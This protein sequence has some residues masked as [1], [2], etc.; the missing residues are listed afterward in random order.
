MKLFRYLFV[1]AA[2]SI[3]PVYAQQLPTWGSQPL[4]A[5]HCSGNLVGNGTN[6]VTCSSTSS[7]FDTLLGSTVGQVAYRN[8]GGWVGTALVP[9]ASGGTGTASPGLTAGTN[10][11]ITGSWPNQ[12]IAASG[13]SSTTTL[14]IGSTPISGGVANAYLYQCSSGNLLCENAA[15]GTGSPVN[16]TS[17]SITTPIIVTSTT[18]NSTNFG[19]ALSVGFDPASVVGIGL[20]ASTSSTGVSI[21]NFESST[22][23][24]VG[25]IR[26]TT[27][28]AGV[29]YNTTSDERL[30]TVN[31]PLNVGK[32]F[33]DIHPVKFTW[34]D[35]SSAP[36]TPSEGFLAQ[37]VYK[38]IPMAVTVGH[39]APGDKDFQPWEMDASRLVPYLWAEVQHQENEIWWLKVFCGGTLMLSLIALI[40][41][42]RG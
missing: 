7:L 28:Q 2:F 10:V 4:P 9:I 35:K 11:T 37:E 41:T 33:E 3:S 12:T 18:I 36:G 6:P 32:A 31:G 24:A 21:M 38:D 40:R 14:T 27:G 26:F 8:S 34:N 29:V 42:R 39:G 16:S 30:K 20:R 22:P 25:S 5:I 19:N 17:P 13:G 1:L 23:A 15:T